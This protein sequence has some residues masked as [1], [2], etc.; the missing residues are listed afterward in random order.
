M[1][2]IKHWIIPIVIMIISATFTSCEGMDGP[3]NPIFTTMIIHIEY[4]GLE[5]FHGELSRIAIFV[6]DENG[7]F[8]VR[9][10]D[11]IEGDEFVVDVKPGKYFVSVEYIESETDSENIIL[12]NAQVEIKEYQTLDIPLKIDLNKIES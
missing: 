1:K 6:T 4:D 7:S 8:I 3:G 12:G 2:T 5:G 10:A 9:Y 11:K